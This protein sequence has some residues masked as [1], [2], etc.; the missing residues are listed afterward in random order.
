MVFRAIVTFSE[1]LNRKDK[2]LPVWYIYFLPFV[3]FFPLHV[4]VFLFPL[5]SVFA[6]IHEVSIEKTI[7]FLLLLPDGPG[8]KTC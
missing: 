2:I 7:L 6:G 1:P 5:L 3:I 8:D 4:D